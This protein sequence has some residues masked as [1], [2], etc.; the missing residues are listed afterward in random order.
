HYD[1]I[2][3]SSIAP[4]TYISFKSVWGRSGHDVFAAGTW[5]DTV[6]HYDGKN[7]NSMDT[8][9]ATLRINAI[10]GTRRNIFTVGGKGIIMHHRLSAVAEFLPS[11]FLLLL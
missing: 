5:G 7:W 10:W 6:L 4:K 3:W 9:R 1:G 11:I 8:G 2:A